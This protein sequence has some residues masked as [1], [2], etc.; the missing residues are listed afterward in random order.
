MKRSG[1]LIAVLV[2]VLVAVGGGYAVFQYGIG[3]IEGEV[4]E[5]LAGNPVVREHLGEIRELELDYTESGAL[6][7][8]EDFAFRVEGTR[9][10]GMIRA[11][12]ITGDDDLEHVTRGTLTLASGETFDL[13][14]EVPGEVPDEVTDEVPGGV[15]DEAHE[16]LMRYGIQLIEEEVRDDLAEHPLIREHLGEIHELGLRLPASGLLPGEDDF[17]FEVRGAK[18]SGVLRGTV[19]TGDDD[20]EHM[21]RGTLTLT[22][23]TVVDLFPAAETDE[24]S[25][26]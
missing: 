6:P 25:D 8:E 11:T 19:I 18:A 26:D 12:V 21:T 4:R 14:P 22:D 3:L 1:C 2:T 17:E 7:G 23:G 9:G 16:E 20:L 10:S 24:P 15:T 5:D 13:F